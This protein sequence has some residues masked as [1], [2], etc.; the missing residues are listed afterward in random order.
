VELMRSFVADLGLDK[1]YLSR[2]LADNR[3]P[4]EF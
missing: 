3:R 2:R 4:F 1:D